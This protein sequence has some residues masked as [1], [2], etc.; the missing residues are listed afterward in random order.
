MLSLAYD[1]HIHSCL[2]PC[3]DNESTPASVVGMAVVNELDVLALTDHNTCKN[4]VAAMEAAK[5]YGIT[6]IPGMELTTEEEVHVVMLMPDLEAAL[7]LD[8]YVNKRLMDVEN[9]ESIFGEQLI[10]DVDDKVIGKERKLLI[11]ATSISFDEAFPL[12]QSFG[13]V[14]IPAH[15]DKSANALF[16]NL[17]FVPPDSTFKTVE[18]KDMT[19]LDS[20]SATHSYL[21]TCKAIS[22]SDAHYLW[23]INL[24]KNFLH[25]EENSAR[26]VIEALKNPSRYLFD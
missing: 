22:S 19:K 24:R 1:L 11:N 17:G 3:G 4:C 7:E 5:A 13:G 10:M 12:A 26:A 16:A 8:E 2:S 21:N 9:V 20:L 25:A 18:L 23:D 6:L 15:I 14:A